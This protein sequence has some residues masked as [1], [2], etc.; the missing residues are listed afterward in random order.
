VR[1]EFTLEDICLGSKH[2]G[3]SKRR[4]VVWLHLLCGELKT[5]LLITQ[6]VPTNCLPMVR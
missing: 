5:C 3:I 1:D 6:K 4:G 2:S